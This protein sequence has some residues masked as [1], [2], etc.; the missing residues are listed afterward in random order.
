MTFSCFLASA[1]WI[2]RGAD[3]ARPRVYG[4]RVVAILASPVI[5]LYHCVSD[6]DKLKM[7]LTQKMRLP[8][9]IA[10]RQAAGA[11]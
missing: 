8:R 10:N 4:P 5:R 3:Y 1:G 11:G 9:P 7:H 6:L 2:A